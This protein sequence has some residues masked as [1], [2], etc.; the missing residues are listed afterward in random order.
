MW[1][2]EP[3]NCRFLRRFR[4]GIASKGNTQAKTLAPTAKSPQAKDR[5]YWRIES[6]V[7]PQPATQAEK[8]TAYSLRVRNT[9]KSGI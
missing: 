8:V 3:F 5:D 2:A 1:Q 6:S 7:V 9:H 4:V